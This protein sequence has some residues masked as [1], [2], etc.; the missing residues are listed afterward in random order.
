[1]NEKRLGELSEPEFTGMIDYLFSDEFD[2]M[3]ASEF[4]GTLQAMDRAEAPKRVLIKGRVQ[5]VKFIPHAVEGAT[6]EDNRIRVNKN[7]IVEILIEDVVREAV[8]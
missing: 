7:S 5:G 8:A 6:L 2:R 4:F 1:M 3:P